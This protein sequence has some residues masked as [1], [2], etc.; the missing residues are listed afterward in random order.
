MEIRKERGGSGTRHAKTYAIFQDKNREGFVSPARDRNIRRVPHPLSC[1]AFQ[2]ARHS[3]PLSPPRPSYFHNRST[4]K[5]S[6]NPS[7]RFDFN[8]EGKLSTASVQQRRRR[9][10]TTTKCG[11][12][13]FSYWVTWS[14]DQLPDSCVRIRLQSGIKWV[15]AYPW[16]FVHALYRI[17]LENAYNRSVIKKGK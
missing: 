6:F 11:E 10:H 14:F 17:F 15:G 12:V 4:N 1:F 7:P 9:R 13:L 16:N 5:V 2:M 8:H 3:S